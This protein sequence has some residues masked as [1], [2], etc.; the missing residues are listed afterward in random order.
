MDAGTRDPGRA[1]AANPVST[2]LRAR[3]HAGPGLACLRGGAVGPSR[4]AALRPRASPFPTTAGALPGSEPRASVGSSGS[5]GQR[6][7]PRHGPH[8]QRHQPAQHEPDEQADAQT[9]DRTCRV[10]AA[11]AG[12]G[13]R[14]RRRLPMRQSSP[15]RPRVPDLAT[16]TVPANESP[17]RLGVPVAEVGDGRRVLHPERDDRVLRADGASIA[18]GLCAFRPTSIVSSAP[19][20]HLRHPGSTS[21]RFRGPARTGRAGRPRPG[22]ARSATVRPTPSGRSVWPHAGQQQ[23]RQQHAAAATR[24]TP[25]TPPRPCRAPTG[26]GGASRRCTATR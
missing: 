20:S 4:P 15:R 9:S 13:A 17:L 23:R 21:L 7:R 25:G 16:A 6:R 12:R 18:A 11:A 8:Q 5:D 26:R 3:I 1:R 19:G 14:P 2:G 24:L 10:A 22:S